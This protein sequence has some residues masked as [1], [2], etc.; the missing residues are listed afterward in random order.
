MSLLHALLELQSRWNI[1]LSVIHINHLLRGEESE[2]DEQFVRRL[3]AEFDLPF[4]CERVDVGSLAAETNLEQTARDVRRSIFRRELDA[5]QLDRVAV[6]HTRSDQAETVLFRLL[7]GSYTT[8]LAGMR[9]STEEGIV[10]PLLQVDRCQV[11]DYLKARGLAWREDRSNQDPQFARNRIR[12]Q[13]MPM[14]VSEWNPQFPRLLAQHAVLAQEDEAYWKQ[15]VERLAPQVFTRNGE[16]LVGDVTQLQVQPAA[17]RRRLIRWAFL[18]IRGDLRQIDF[19]HIDQA[20]ALIGGPSGHARIQVPGVDILR[21]FEWVRFVKP[22]T[23]PAERDF[24][25]PLQIPGRCSLPF[26]VQILTLDVVPMPHPP[27]PAPHPSHVTLETDLDWNR[28][29]FAMGSE[30]LILRNWRP[31]DTYQPVGNQREHKLKTLFHEGRVPLWERRH[32]PVVTVGGQIVWSRKFGPASHVA[33]DALSG[34]ILRISE[35]AQAS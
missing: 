18:H 5:G 19:G 7:R 3:A 29:R 11:E 25:I 28:I 24:E 8:G 17:L 32:W 27:V 33:A 12:H 35:R 15:Q 20:L 6:A 34:T 16:S 10:R 31:G 2:K 1:S 26:S 22:A 9:C 30:L 21:S 4:L 14:L 13:L 23:G